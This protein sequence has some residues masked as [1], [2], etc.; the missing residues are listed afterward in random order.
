[1]KKLKFSKP[2]KIKESTLKNRADRLMS[3][4]VRSIGYCQARIFTKVKLSCFVGSS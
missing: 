4:K 3:L 1:M 2:K